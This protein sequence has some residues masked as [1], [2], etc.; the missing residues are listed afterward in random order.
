[1][2]VYEF[3]LVLTVPDVTEED[4]D[5]LYKAG[6]DDGTIVT[7]EMKTHIAFDR[8]ATSLEEAIRSATEDVRSAGFD[9]AKIEM[10]TLSHSS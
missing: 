7:R 10:E 1:M 5:R 9:V 2:Q 4:C 8:E 3:S 6:C